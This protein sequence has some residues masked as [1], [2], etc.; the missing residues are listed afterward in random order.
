MTSP[1]LPGLLDPEEL[2]CLLWLFDEPL[3]A[4]WLNG[5]PGLE[6]GLLQDTN[7]PFRGSIRY[8]VQ[9]SGNKLSLC[10]TA[11]VRNVR[12]PR[13][14]QSLIDDFSLTLQ[15]GTVT[16]AKARFTAQP[17]RQIVIATL[18]VSV[19]DLTELDGSMFHLADAG[20]YCWEHIH[21]AGCGRQG[22][23]DVD[24]TWSLDPDPGPA[25]TA[26][27]FCPNCLTGGSI[28]TAPRGMQFYQQFSTPAHP[29]H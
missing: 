18:V 7:G 15:S 17:P 19:N 24:S 22:V 14:D 6:H 11:E 23:N 8:M 3:K 29:V 25:N 4:D 26:I 10:F 9:P 21:C 2:G 13:F 20:R 5:R 27:R 16:L 12:N 1:P 28:A